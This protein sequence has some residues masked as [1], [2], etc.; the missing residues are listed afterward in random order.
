M[1]RGGLRA[2]G[3]FA[4]GAVLAAQR[5]ACEQLG[6]RLELQVGE[7]AREQVVD[8]LKV[9]DGGLTEL[10]LPRLGQLRVGDARVG[11]TG[12]LLDEPGAFEPVEEN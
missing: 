7:A 2:T 12:V 5:Q 3:G 11:R 10:A 1:G 6:E 9:G 4:G 8:P